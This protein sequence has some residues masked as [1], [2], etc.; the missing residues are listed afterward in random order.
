MYLQFW[1]SPEP[2]LSK[3]TP[4][5]SL[6]YVLRV[7]ADDL[8]GGTGPEVGVSVPAPADG[9]VDSRESGSPLSPAMMLRFDQYT[10]NLGGKGEKGRE[11]ERERVVKIRDSSLF[12]ALFVAWKSSE[13]EKMV[14]AMSLKF[15]MTLLDPIDLGK[16]R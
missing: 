8:I 7:E 10:V 1:I 2:P 11:R 5:A 4:T 9:C 15:P 3:V 13:K 12:Y 14:K 6:P 16:T